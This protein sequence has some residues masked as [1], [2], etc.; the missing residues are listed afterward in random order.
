MLR[1][2]PCFIILTLG[3]ITNPSSLPSTRDL[4]TALPHD[5]SPPYSM[6]FV[7][8]FVKSRRVKVMIYGSELIEPVECCHLVGL[9]KSGVVEDGVA[10]E[11]D[12]AA[13]CHHR[14]PDVNYFGR[15]FP[16]GVNA[17]YF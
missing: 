6:T 1:D 2:V 15:V 16:D 14:L 3:R 17:Q 11:L 4:A 8:P 9:S 12:G 5:L 7:E 13:Q 10:E